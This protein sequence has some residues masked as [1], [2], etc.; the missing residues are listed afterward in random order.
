MLAGRPGNSRDQDHVDEED[1]R[2]QVEWTLRTLD[3]TATG[4]C[5]DFGLDS[6]HTRIVRPR[7]SARLRRAEPWNAARSVPPALAYLGAPRFCNRHDGLA[8][9]PS[10]RQPIADRKLA[11]G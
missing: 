7:T 6:R 5:K 4:R 9:S 2:E 11:D 3:P 8:P 10:E 1:D